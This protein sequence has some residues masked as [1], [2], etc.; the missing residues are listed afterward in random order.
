[1]AQVIACKRA[2]ESTEFA[3]KE[4]DRDRPLGTIDERK[5]NPNGGAIALGHPVGMT[6]T[7]MVLTLLRSLRERGGGRGL[8]TLCVGG[9]QGVAVVVETRLES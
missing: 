8:A 3:R 5:L 9:G 1:A 7:R 6:G 4:L 2:F